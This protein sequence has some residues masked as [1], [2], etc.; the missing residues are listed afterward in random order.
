MSMN[1][2]VRQ[3]GDVTV[4]DLSGRISPGESLADRLVLQDLVREQVNTGHNKILLNLREVTYIN[5]SGIAGLLA[6]LKAVR[7]RG[8]ELRICNASSRVGH[9]LRTTHLDS[10]FAFDKDEPAA[11]QTFTG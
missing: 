7:E 4:L 2:A 10:V 1:Y 9:V 11:L 5:S 6:S 8:G 3:I